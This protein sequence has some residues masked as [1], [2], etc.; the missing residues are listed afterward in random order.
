MGRHAGGASLA[1]Y[2]KARVSRRP[3]LR[4]DLNENRFAAAPQ[5]QRALQRLNGDEL[6][7]YPEDGP[8]RRS[9]ARMLLGKGMAVHTAEDGAS[10]LELLGR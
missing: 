8:L 1:A 2:A 5:V 3:F 10:A 6:A 4:L 7:M 9:L